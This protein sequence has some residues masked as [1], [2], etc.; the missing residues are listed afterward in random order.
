MLSLVGW[1]VVVWVIWTAI[2]GVTMWLVRF[3]MNGQQEFVGEQ[4][5][6][7]TAVQV[8]EGQPDNAASAATGTAPLRPA[9]PEHARPRAPLGPPLSAT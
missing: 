7:I 3:T 8:M 2:F 9:L 4:E 6:A 5:A 1:L